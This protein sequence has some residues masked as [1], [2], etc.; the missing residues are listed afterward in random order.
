MAPAPRN[1]EELDGAL[2]EVDFV[3][4]EKA[5]CQIRQVRDDNDVFIGYKGHATD[6]FGAMIETAQFDDYAAL[7]QCLTEAGFAR[8]EV[9]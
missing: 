3:N 4:N 1:L 6:E 9:V 7:M 2:A 8:I 5:I